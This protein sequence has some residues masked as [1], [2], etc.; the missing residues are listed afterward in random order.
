MAYCK[1]NCLTGKSLPKTSIGMGMDAIAA[2][3][4]VRRS[5]PPGCGISGIW[6]IK[7]GKNKLRRVEKVRK[8][9]A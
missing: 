3:A 7:S 2:S 4:C 6:P 8:R 5:Q 9:V 1:K